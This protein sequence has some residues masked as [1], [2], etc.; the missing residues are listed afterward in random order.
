MKIARLSMV[1]ALA[2]GAS[3]V[4]AAEPADAAKAQYDAERARCMSGTTGQDQASCLRSAGAAYDSIRQN[5]L[6]DPNSNFRENALT[7][8]RA[9]PPADRADCEAR[10]AGESSTSGSVKGGGV[11]KES[12]TRT[13]GPTVMQPVPAQS[14]T[15]A[16]PDVPIKPR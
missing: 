9:L 3:N 7:R 12:V 13:T 15:D 10:V 11:Y 8:C 2:L 14:G 1:V 16:A 6:Q 4:Y 5:R